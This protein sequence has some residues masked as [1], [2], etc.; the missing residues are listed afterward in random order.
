MATKEKMNDF[1]RFI[2]AAEKDEALLDDF[3]RATRGA[4]GLHKFFQDKGFKEISIDDCRGI[5]QVAEMNKEVV[6][7]TFKMMKTAADCTGRGY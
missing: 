1:I 7:M 4:E 5:V 2:L 6:F 3:L